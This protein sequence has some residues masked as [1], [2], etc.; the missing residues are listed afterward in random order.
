MSFHQTFLGGDA[1]AEHIQQGKTAFVN[2]IQLTGTKAQN[3]GIQVLCVPPTGVSDSSFNPSS[4]HGALIIANPNITF[5]ANTGWVLDTN[6]FSTNVTGFAQFIEASAGV[7]AYT[8]KRKYLLWGRFADV[9]QVNGAG[10]SIVFNRTDGNNLW[11]AIIA[12]SS[13][14]GRFDVGLFEI[15]AGVSTLRASANFS[16][17]LD[18]PAEFTLIVH[19]QGDGVVVQCVMYETDVVTDDEGVSCAYTVS[20]RPHKASTAFRIC[21]QNDPETAV[22]VRGCMVHDIS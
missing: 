12:W 13:S 10:V 17:A 15:T 16:T 8:T 4:E 22:A 20:S 7:P 3:S 6:G 1:L 11:N 9:T 18:L 19:E 21:L 2:N 14:N 5:S